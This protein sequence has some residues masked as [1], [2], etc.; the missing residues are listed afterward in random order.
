MLVILEG[1]DGT[2]KTTL[3]KFLA[4]VLNAEII[5]CTA[6]T[7]N[8]YIFFADIVEAARDRNIIADRFCYGQFV[9]QMEHERPLKEQQLR[10][11]ETYML[12]QGVKLIHVKAPQS[13]VEACLAERGENTTIPVKDILERFETVLSNSILPVIEYN[14]NSTL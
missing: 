2:G 3:A 7:P 13:V 12:Q 9:Y 1:C 8:T 10:T 6:K 14:T 4:Q 5:H 11:L